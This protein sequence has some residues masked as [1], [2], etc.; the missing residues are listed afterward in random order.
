MILKHLK[1]LIQNLL[2][3]AF[4]EDR[5]FPLNVLTLKLIWNDSGSWNIFK[6][7]RCF[8]RAKAMRV[9]RI[10]CGGFIARKV[11]SAVLACK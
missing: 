1:L 6:L 5:S 8:E 2:V 3:S 11:K 10:I 7:L 4:F 9:H